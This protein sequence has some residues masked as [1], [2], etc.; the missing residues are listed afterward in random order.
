[1]QDTAHS[2][3]NIRPVRELYVHW[4]LTNS[5]GNMARDKNQAVEPALAHQFQMVF[6][7]EEIARASLQTYLD[8]GSPI[9]NATSGTF[10]DRGSIW[11]QHYQVAEAYSDTLPAMLNNCLQIWAQPHEDESNRGRSDV[12]HR[13]PLHLCSA[14]GFEGLGEVYLQMGKDPNILAH[15]DGQTALHLAS[16]GGHIGMIE[17]LLGRDADMEKTTF[18]TG[19]TA[20][21]MAAARGHEDAVQLLLGEGAD[22]DATDKL[23]H[24]A[25][26]LAA[27]NGH[28]EIVEL[29]ITYRGHN[30]MGL[31]WHEETTC[32]RPRPTSLDCCPCGEG[33]KHEK[34]CTHCTNCKH[35]QRTAQRPT[36]DNRKEEK[37]SHRCCCHSGK[38]PNHRQCGDGPNSS[39][40]SGQTKSN[41][42]DEGWIALDYH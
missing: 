22:V 39:H 34:N 16:A 8:V 31:G 10:E 7:S 41:E 1:M 26:E 13:S 3:E 14:F 40:C 5:N 21:Q 11:P 42:V 36:R 9:R 28:E 29:L 24:T 38:G 32:D 18:H 12:F 17:K 20:L 37:Q 15:P 19:R 25:L 23:G 33:P 35:K 6:Q 30:S 4:K 2:Y 27:Q